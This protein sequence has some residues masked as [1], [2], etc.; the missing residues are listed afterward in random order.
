MRRGAMALIH[1][2]PTRRQLSDMDRRLI[3]I[4]EPLFG[5]APDE[6]EE[7]R[8]NLLRCLRGPIRLLNTAEDALTPIVRYLRPA[9]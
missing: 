8:L 6:F 4:Y 1:I 9:L 3:N 5:G 7:V 2:Q